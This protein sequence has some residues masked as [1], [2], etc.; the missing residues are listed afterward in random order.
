MNEK[1]AKEAKEAK[2][3][4]EKSELRKK[5]DEKKNKTKKKDLN[6]DD[7]YMTTDDETKT[8]NPMNRKNLADDFFDERDKKDDAIIKKRKRNEFLNKDLPKPKRKK[9]VFDE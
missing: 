7:V 4:K 6:I 3:T 1:E 9:I 5:I 8:E 2:Q